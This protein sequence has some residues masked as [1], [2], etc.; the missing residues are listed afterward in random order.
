M[1]HSWPAHVHVF[2]L[3]VPE[4]CNVQRCLPCSFSSPRSTS[5]RRLPLPLLF[6]QAA[7]RAAVATEGLTIR[8]AS[9]VPTTSVGRVRRNVISQPTRIGVVT[10]GVIDRWREFVK[11]RYNPE[12]R[13]LNLEVSITQPSLPPFPEPKFSRA[14]QNIQADEFIKKNNLIPIGAGTSA[15]EAA[16]VFKIAKELKP[17]VRPS[18]CCPRIPVF[19]SLQVETISLARN[20]ISSGQMLS[21]LP[22]Y[23][24]RLKNLSLEGNSIRLWREVDAIAGRGTK[25]E[26]LR[27]LILTGNPIRELEYQNNRADK[28]KRQVSRSPFHAT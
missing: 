27:E 18:A 22:H 26:Q 5:R 3:S 4:F 12:A 25:F 9:K 23:L 13:F 6:L 8:G 11:S 14:P 16:V 17:E 15:R 21:T 19:M 7:A 24:P 20:R 28:Y 1:R 2:T 10:S